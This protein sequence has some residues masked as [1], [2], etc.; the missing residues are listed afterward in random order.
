MEDYPR[1][2][3]DRL[4][5]R[6][7]D[8]SDGPNVERLAGAWEV[9][10]TTLTI[11]HP[12]PVGGAAQ[13]IATHLTAWQR[14]DN[15]TLAVCAQASSELLGAIGLQFS[16]THLHGE[17]GYWIGVNSWGKGIAT[18]AARGVTGYA[19]TELGLHRVQGRHFT[20][21]AAS[22]RVLQK[23]GMRLEGVHRDAY[24][25][26]GRF[27][28]VGV[29]AVLASEWNAATQRTLPEPANERRS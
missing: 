12:Y 3:M 17:I 5:L 29:Y 22:G 27:E 13:W 7:F 24:R 10:D 4:V 8:A 21:N 16:L 14:R 18:E 6:P 20:R 11:P 26:W 1:L 19:F 25:R 15:L 23:L 9:A 28:D 2:V